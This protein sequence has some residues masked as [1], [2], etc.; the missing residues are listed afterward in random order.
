MSGLNHNLP[1]TADQGAEAPGRHGQSLVQTAASAS[2]EAVDLA[3]EG[4]GL[5]CPP[6]GWSAV[7]GEDPLNKWG[8]NNRHSV[9]EMRLG[10]QGTPIYDLTIL[11]EDGKFLA[12]HGGIIMPDRLD[13]A[14]EAA[15]VALA[16]YQ[17]N[18]EPSANPS[19]A[20]YNRVNR[21]LASIPQRLRADQVPPV[22]PGVAWRSIGGHYDDS[23]PHAHCRKSALPEGSVLFD[24]A[25]SQGHYQTSWDSQVLDRRTAAAHIEGTPLTEFPPEPT[26]FLRFDDDEPGSDDDGFDL[27]EFSAAQAQA[28]RER[29]EL[30]DCE[31]ADNYYIP[32]CG[33]DDTRD[34]RGRKLL[35]KV[36]DAG[37]PRGY[38]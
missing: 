33:P 13:S 4:L 24:P 22:I 18:A 3:P 8:L 19:L 37:E 27:G 17:E 12:A 7:C 21:A 2:M 9:F 23:S 6:E 36:N 26:R 29:D 11:T 38:M 30:G 1:V 34:S 32:G 5:A 31:Q 10:G 28:L 25:R 35:P 20:Y 14:E 16:W 15:R